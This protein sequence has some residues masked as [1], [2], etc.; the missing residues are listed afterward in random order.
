[1]EQTGLYFIGMVIIAAAIALFAWCFYVINKGKQLM[2]TKQLNDKR[3]APLQLQAYERL[4]LFLERTDLN[5]LVMRLNQPGMTA[6][7]LH[8]ELLKNVRKEYEH[9]LVQQLY[10]SDQVWTLIVSA[11]DKNIQTIN[12]ASD[13]IGKDE[14]SVLLAREIIGNSGQPNKTALKALKIEKR[15]RF[16]V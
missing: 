16:G 6:Q 13:K 11:R 9:N 10:V 8:V 3:M 5:N 14:S 7:L 15:A 1:M 4:V 2:E 12:M